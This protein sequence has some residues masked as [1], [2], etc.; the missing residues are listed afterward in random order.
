LVVTAD[1]NDWVLA[2]GGTVAAMVDAGAEA[3]LLRVCNDD[4]DSWDLSPEETALRATQDSEAAAKIL[5]VAHVH[6]LGY[7]MGEL[8]AERHT[9][10]RDRVLVYIRR[11][12][13]D[14]LFIPNPYAA[15]V[16]A[17]D[18]FYVGKAAEDA[19]RAAGLENF[20]PP[21]AVVGLGP[22]VAPEVYY[23]A[24]PVDPRRR[25]AESTATFVP[26]PV[27]R[28]IASTF[29]KKLRAA[30]A[31]KTANDAMARR[32][33]QRLDESNRRLALLDEVNETSIQKLVEINVTK[34]AEIAARDTPYK[35]AEEF[36]YAGPDYQLPAIFRK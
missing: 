24:Q 8:A 34:L 36:H 18:R 29:A 17:L 27:Q 25:E 33:R 9:E 23:Y 22:H 30:Q 10:I 21:H 4:K 35:Q 6:S 28:D 11:Y 7:R 15:Y 32:I 12:K 26:Q 13:P 5:G 1:Q 31:L 16:E 19:W 20:Q 2:A 14:V 3:H